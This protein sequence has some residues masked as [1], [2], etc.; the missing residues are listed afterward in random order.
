[1]GI[2]YIAWQKIPKISVNLLDLQVRFIEEEGEILYG[3]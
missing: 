2:I 1:M 3:L